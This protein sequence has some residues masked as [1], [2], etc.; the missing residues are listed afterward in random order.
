M[1]HSY[2]KIA[3]AAVI[4]QGS[5]SAAAQ[6]KQ[7]AIT[8]L[9]ITSGLNCDAIAEKYVSSTSDITTTGGGKL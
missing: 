4:A 1:K 5:L 8:P 2:I 9:K 3:M 7:T 6:E